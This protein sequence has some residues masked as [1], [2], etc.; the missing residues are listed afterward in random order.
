MKRFGVLMD[1]DL[2]DRFLLLF[3]IYGQRSAIIRK[4]V[5]RIVQAGEAKGGAWSFDP[6]DIADDMLPKED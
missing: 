5:L 1:A 2:Y 3:P 6:D 4:I